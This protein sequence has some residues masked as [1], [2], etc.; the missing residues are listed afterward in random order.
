MRRKC[1]CSWWTVQCSVKDDIKNVT[2]CERSAVSL[3]WPSSSGQMEATHNTQ[4]CEL[5]LWNSRHVN[6]GV[7]C[8]LLPFFTL[9]VAIV[10][11]NNIPAMFHGPEGIV[12]KRKNDLMDSLTEDYSCAMSVFSNI[13]QQR[14][15]M[16]V[17]LC[18][19]KRLRRTDGQTEAEEGKEMRVR[20]PWES[21]P[22]GTLIGWGTQTGS[23]PEACTDTTCQ[24]KQAEMSLC[25]E[26]TPPE[27]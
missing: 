25:D 13:S 6:P 22:W 5:R 17:L 11:K 18:E 9:T 3:T 12:D 14:N 10:W 4:T 8:C 16:P 24:L 23:V 7:C 15:S 26:W 19:E 27:V 20:C 2:P 21:G 1:N